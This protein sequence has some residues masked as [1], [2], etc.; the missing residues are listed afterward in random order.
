MEV[1]AAKMIGAA[2]AVLPL[3]GV[4]LG[5]GKIFATLIESVARNPEARKDVFS[6][7]I[8]GFALTEAVALFALLVAFLILFK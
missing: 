7:G 8:L 2:I 1:E 6:I 5:I 3:F 4:G